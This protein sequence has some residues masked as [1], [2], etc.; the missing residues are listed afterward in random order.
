MTTQHTEGPPEEGVRRWRRLKGGIAGALSALGVF[1]L[2]SSRYAPNRPVTY[3]GIEDHFKYGSIGGDNTENGL[4]LRVM[5]ILPRMFHEHLQGGRDYTTFGF[6]QEPGRP[7]PVG[8][9]IRRRGIDLV[10]LNCAVCHVGSVRASEDS[11]PVRYLGMPANTVDLQAYF[12]FLFR[13][14]EDSRFT[15]DLVIDEVEKDGAL[16][17]PERLV[18]R[19]AVEEMRRGILRARDRLYV[20]TPLNPPFGPGRVDTFNPYKTNQFGEYYQGHLSAEERLGTVDFPSVWNQRPREGMHLH[21]DGDNTSVMERNVSAAF[22]AGATRADVDLPRIRRVKEW[23]DVLPPPAF[24]F[25]RSEDP[26][27]LR[28]GQALYDAYCAGCHAIGGAGVGR[29]VPI[30]E[31]GTDEH[32]LNSYTTTLRQLQV[33]Y[34]RGYDWEF[35]HFQKTNGYAN[36]PLDGIWARAPY[37]HNGSV[38]T[39]WDLLTPAERRPTRFYR[40]H[41][42]YDPVRVGF[43]VDVREVEGRRAFLFETSQP[44]NSSRGH[45]GARYGTE[46]SDSDKWALIEYLKTL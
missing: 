32:R 15:P 17:P 14:A 39:L 28:Q 45:T 22:G 11:A 31:I 3:E 8:F 10:G 13:C 36:Q 44:G 43:R 38:P 12:E 24:P 23:L 25:K 26:A 21:W 6:I 27:K 16:F 30:E 2:L 41:D 4:P 40:G 5:Q 20:F 46:L 1:L 7:M 34:D 29:V 37:L 33:R 35:R 42:V 9:S 19:G 18:Y